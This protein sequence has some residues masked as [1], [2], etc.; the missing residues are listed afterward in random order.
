MNDSIH[1]MR[2]DELVL[3]YRDMQHIPIDTKT[4]KD[5]YARD[6]FQ[7]LLLEMASRFAIMIENEELEDEEAADGL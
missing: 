7:R 6:Y 5:V 1:S 4:D 2:N 3:H